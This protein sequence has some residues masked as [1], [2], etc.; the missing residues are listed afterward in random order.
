MCA[1]V[2][3]GESTPAQHTFMST[4]ARKAV[5]RNCAMQH[6][7]LNLPSYRS[8]SAVQPF[9]QAAMWPHSVG[10]TR[11]STSSWL[12]AQSSHHHTGIKF[13]VSLAG[14]QQP[15]H[16]QPHNTPAPRNPPHSREPNPQPKEANG[17]TDGAKVRRVIS[18]MRPPMLRV[19]SEKTL[20][21][22]PGWGL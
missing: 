19:A 6:T 3:T 8:H 2:W 22:F 20:L 9:D 4:I 13:L 11:P 10:A 18:L 15:T 5:K 14:N 1:A 16:T 17:A 7:R 21:K 12:G